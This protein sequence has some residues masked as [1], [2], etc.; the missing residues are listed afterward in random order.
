VL[1]T[2]PHEVWRVI[3]TIEELSSICDCYN[4]PRPNC[5]NRANHRE[6]SGSA[7]GL[8][9]S[10]IRAPGDD[11]FPL[12]GTN[13]PTSIDELKTAIRGG[14]SEVLTLSNPDNTVR[15]DGGAWPALNRL[16]IDLNNATIR[17]T[18]PP[19][20]PKPRDD[21]Q[22][23]IT[24]AN[25][26]VLGHPIRYARSSADFSLSASG[27]ALDFAH[28]QT[29]RALLLLRDAASGHLEM[30]IDKSDLQAALLDAAT[31]AAKP[32]GI[33][34]QDLQLNLTSDGPRSLA[35]ELRVKAKKM[36]MSGVVLL[37]GR[38]DISDA[39]V[40]TLSNLACS[41]EGMIGGMAAAM[42]NTKLKS[43]E[44]KTIPL[45]A[46]SLG[47]TALRDLTITAGQTIAVTANFGR[48]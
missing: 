43:F 30:K 5:E 21:R 23:G 45:A 25:I 26:E 31:A 12:S 15:I 32:H 38:V 47:D 9:F 18:Q 28:D 24:V 41:G 35:G 20:K 11:M 7:A 29:G 40:A 19:P 8:F 13:F 33:S 44:G 46:M 16:T 17:I 4:P 22:P 37:R 3:A 27:V 42:V 6:P 39:L 14:L 2:G 10:T 36:M 34:I 1:L 48:N